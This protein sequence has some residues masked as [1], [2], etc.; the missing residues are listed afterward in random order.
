MRT[1]I[2]LGTVS[3]VAKKIEKDLNVVLKALSYFSSVKVFLVESDSKDSTLEVLESLREK[4][5]NF[6]Y[7]TLGQLKDRVPDRIERIRIC[8]NEYIQ[9]I[10]S[11]KSADLPE[12]VIIADLDGMNGKLTHKA[13]TSCFVRSDWD[14]V[15]SNQRGGYYDI[16]ALRHD[17][18]QP[19]DYNDELAWYRSLV[20]PKRPNYLQ[21]YESLRLRF[22]YDQ[23]RN[24]AIYRKMLRFK[25]SHPWIEVNSAFGGIGIYKSE[26]LLKYDYSSEHD[27][28]KGISEHVSFHSKMR[29]DGL[30]LFINPAFINEG[31]NTYN[32]NRFLLIRQARQLLWNSRTISNTLNFMR[33]LFQ[34]N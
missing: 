28:G 22:N 9:F 10:R 16:L 30:K 32:I 1:C 18:W 14:A 11:L 20:I 6:E 29:R 13:I 25:I 2:L 15:F 31:W 24:Y 5:S 17:I 4:K 27:Y 21:L 8:R 33:G 34:K 23:A 3:N 12:Y 26:V 19:L 7:I